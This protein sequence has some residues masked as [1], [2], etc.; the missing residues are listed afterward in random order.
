MDVSVVL[1]VYNEEGNVEPLFLE[2]REVLDQ[3][4]DQWEVIFVDD[5]S[6]D[7]TSEKLSDICTENS[8]VTVVELKT[9]FGQT[10]AIQAGIDCS[11]GDLVVTMDSDMQNDPEDIPKLSRYMKETRSDMVNGWRKD[12]QDPLLKKMFSKAAAVI[13]RLFLGTELHDYGCTLKVIRKEAAEEL[14]LDGEMH[15]Y[16]PPLLKMK[17]YKVTE[18]SVNHRP[19]NSG[20]T[21]YS[22][23]RLPKGFIDLL[24][25]WFWQKYQG[26]PIHIFGGLGLISMTLGILMSF[27][28]VYQKVVEGV[29]FSDTGA[30]IISVF[31]ILVGVQFFI[32]GIMTDILIKNHKKVSS[33]RSYYI[34][35][36]KRG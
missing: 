23:Q 33:H 22:Y 31:L 13:R 17:G 25:V 30:T 29:G 1:P 8:E 15:R 26:R 11:K 9:N 20:K 27:Y 36:I 10:P 19:R 21:S 4:F 32:S 3:N 28:T 12:R 6:T 14:D 7:S 2:L 35:D 24:N 34:E 5:G 16:V 18:M